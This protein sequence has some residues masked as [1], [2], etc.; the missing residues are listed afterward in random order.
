MDG[1]MGE[2]LGEGLGER[3]EQ[4]S[5]ECRRDC[6]LRDHPRGLC[7]SIHSIDLPQDLHHAQALPS[8]HI[9]QENHPSN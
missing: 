6:S 4:G 8:H 1:V 9:L 7:I 3:L 5:M 2:G